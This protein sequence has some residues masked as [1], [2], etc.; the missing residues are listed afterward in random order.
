MV[1]ACDDASPGIASAP[2]SFDGESHAARAADCSNFAPTPNTTSAPLSSL[3]G[4]G[5][6]LLGLEGPPVLAAVARNERATSPDWGQEVRT[7]SLEARCG[8]PPLAWTAGDVAWLLP[9]NS[10]EAVR[11]ML[12]YTR[13]G[14]GTVLELLT[15]G[16]SGP[17]VDSTGGPAQ[18][19]VLGGG[20]GGS[21]RL[22]ITAGE[23]F[24]RVLAVE[25]VPRPFAF[26]QLSL[27]A[28]EPE[29]RA[30]LE[31]LGSARGA[32]LYHDYCFRE[33][34]GWYEV[35][36]EFG[37]LAVPLS[38]LFSLIPRLQPRAF[39]IASPPPPPPRADA[40]GQAKAHALELCVAV[41]RYETRYRR[42]RVGVCS[43]WLS[44][45]PS[46]V[47]L[48][49][50]PGTF[51]PALI[52]DLSKPL[53][54]VGPGTGVAPMRAIALSRRA[55]GDLLFFG[56]RHAAKDWLYPDLGA[57]VATSNAFSRD[58]P[59]DAPRVYVTHRLAERG[60]EVW[61]KL[62]AGGAV[63]VAGAAGSMPK[64][65]AAALAGVAQKHGGLSETDAR[66]LV[67]RLERQ[68]R[69]CVEAYR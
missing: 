54:L 16:G 19:P 29:D 2:Q 55:P 61:A 51:P 15:P 13:L 58:V 49:V 52:A 6:A 69:L 64:D 31:E 60:A 40:Q 66:A 4:T 62:C 41:V 25:A 8:E 50:R 34:R 3:L 38:H 1:G 35:L 36:R 7:V 46:E 63:F 67:K 43:G 56:C 23:L 18:S 26:E 10:P 48:W 45:G 20:G 32:D 30:K 39:S 53:V 59:R 33:R 21:G 47:A 65:V 68:R 37:S 22:R 42:R 57:H 28:G 5:F 27:H 11:A 24:G 44:R 12:E 9:E 14:H 17:N